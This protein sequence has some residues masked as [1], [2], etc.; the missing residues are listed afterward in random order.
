M[1]RAIASGALT[2]MH[3]LL[4]LILFRALPN[5]NVST[6]AAA[7]LPMVYGKSMCIGVSAPPYAV[8]RHYD[9]CFT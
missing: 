5:S 1:V 9:A 8:Q 7:S 2:A 3:A 4:V 6:G